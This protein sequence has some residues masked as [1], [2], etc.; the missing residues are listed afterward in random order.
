MIL[1]L[2]ISKH[3][4]M[5]SR[6]PRSITQIKL[7]EGFDFATL[8][9]HEI[10]I[11]YD[12]TNRE[13]NVSL[14]ELLRSIIKVFQKIWIERD[15]NAKAGPATEFM[16]F[17]EYQGSK[18]NNPM[19]SLLILRMTLKFAKERGDE[20]MKENV[21]EKMKVEWRKFLDWFNWH[22]DDDEEGE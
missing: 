14:F 5:S 18:A 2:I 7:M 9:G 13:G 22:D 20:D 1:D 15:I 4:N 3:N 8:T 11:L 19:Y 6:S 10:E 12:F 21:L 16:D 17:S